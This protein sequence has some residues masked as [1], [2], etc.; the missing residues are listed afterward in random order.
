MRSKWWLI[1]LAFI[2]AA[3]NVQIALSV[4]APRPPKPHRGP[5]T[6]KV[7]PADKE[8]NVVDGYGATA[9][10]ARKIALQNASDRVETLL[11]DSFPEDNWSPSPGLLSGDCLV[12]YGVVQPQGEPTQVDRDRNNPFVAR[13]AVELTQPYKDEVQRVA[14]EERIE[15]RQLILVRVLIGLV[16]LLLVLAGYL[17]L[18]DMTR[19]YATQLLRVAAFGL[20]ALTTLVLWLTV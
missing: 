19:G 13:Y 14:L 4:G 12:R 18:E 5:R 17:R 9:A 1:L 20:V 15:G 3:V 8:D 10:T 16:V 6:Q 2:A 7:R 11:K